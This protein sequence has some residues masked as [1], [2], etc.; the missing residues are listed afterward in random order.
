MSAVDADGR[1]LGGL[2]DVR[3]EERDEGWVVTHAIFG[4]AAVAERL[5][6]IHGVVE[7]PALL[8][9]I[10]RRLALHTRVVPWD[11]LKVTGEGVVRTASARGELERPEGYR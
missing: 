5:G 6:F 7:R 2:K 1:S 10:L 3:L 9:R 4:R 11:E 8:A